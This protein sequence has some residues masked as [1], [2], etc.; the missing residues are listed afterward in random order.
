MWHGVRVSLVQ[1][2]AITALTTVDSDAHGH[3]S[4]EVA[5]PASATPGR[6][7]IRVEFAEDAALTID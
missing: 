3:V 7:A 2:A 5:I 6:A 1:G 4:T